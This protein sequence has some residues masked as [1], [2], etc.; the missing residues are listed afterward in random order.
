MSIFISI[1]SLPDPELLATIDNIYETAD[2]PQ[3]VNIG[4]HL[5]GWNKIKAKQIISSIRQ[6]DNRVK[7][8]VTNLGISFE[9]KVS[10][11]GV[12]Y[13][14][15]ISHSLYSGEDYALQIDSHSLFAQSWD[16]KL[17][18]ILNEA[19]AELGSDKVILTAYAGMYE[20]RKFIDGPLGLFL[21]P[22]YLSGNSFYANGSIPSWDIDQLPIEY[23][24]KKFLPSIKFNANFAFSRGK[25]MLNTGLNS[26]SMFYD[27]EISQTLNLLKNNWMLVFPVLSEPIIGHLYLNE[28]TANIRKSIFNYFKNNKVEIL[29]SM[30]KDRFLSFIK[31][32]SNSD[33]IK[34]YEKWARVNLELGSIYNYTHIPKT[35]NLE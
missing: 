18:E 15:T 9:K 26:N 33:I 7:V 20:N 17:I 24:N 12:G 23:N 25:W 11:L 16:S 13:G 2:N 28:K 4:L 6:Y 35:F 22:T 10:K 32:K 5:I 30:Q 3:K 27:E 19:E 31:D 14:R 21:Y 29:K 1:A 34:L 8:I